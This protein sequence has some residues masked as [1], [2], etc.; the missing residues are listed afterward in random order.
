[1]AFRCSRPECGRVVDVLP[2]DELCPDCWGEMRQ[3]DD[4]GSSTQPSAALRRQVG[5]CAVICDV[6]LT[7][8]E[9]VP[10]M[11]LPGTR[12]ADVPRRVDL[13]AQN[14]SRGIWDLCKSISK[15]DDAWLAL[16]GFGEDAGLLRMPDGKPF[17]VSA[18]DIRDHFA[19]SSELEQHIAEEFQY[20]I[21]LWGKGTNISCGLEKARG[22][23]DALR[24]NDISQFGGPQSVEM[25]EHDILAW[26]DS[27]K[28]IPNFRAFI[29]SDGDH[30][31]GQLLNPFADGE[32]S[33][34][35]WA[36]LMTAFVGSEAHLGAA[37]MQ[38]ISGVCPQHGKRNFFL[39]NNPRRYQQLSGLFR[40]ASGASG[41]C[42]R[43]LGEQQQ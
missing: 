39:I 22:I 17:L 34:V 43:C 20:H 24:A 19:S 28:T 30:N 8:Q 29:F 35:P 21:D 37:Q 41:F 27:E 26:D 42:P 18:R 7:M 3:F 38:D 32:A 11:A 12:P 16:I 15:A 40:M 1:M 4:P 33:D 13:V 25:I 10:E 23:F 36:L 2:I 14:A 5:L 9:R 6:S 31:R